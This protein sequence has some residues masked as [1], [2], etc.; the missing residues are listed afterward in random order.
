MFTFF[1]AQL[2]FWFETHQDPLNTGKLGR[3]S[4]IVSICRRLYYPKSNFFHLVV[5][6]FITEGSESIFICGTTRPQ[7]VPDI[8]WLFTPYLPLACLNYPLPP[9][10]P[11][12]NTTQLS[13]FNA[14]FWL[15]NF[16]H[17]I[18]DFLAFNFFISILEAY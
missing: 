17:S 14:K 15:F 10:P 12:L 13:F 16:C 5:S 2:Y 18:F 9:S 8:D 6:L 3:S 7:G 1:C 4:N 11:P